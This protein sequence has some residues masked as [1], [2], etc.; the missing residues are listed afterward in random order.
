M[1]GQVVAERRGL[2][3]REYRTNQNRPVRGCRGP[4]GKKHI[5]FVDDDLNVLRGLERMLRPLRNEWEMA[6]LGKGT[7]AL[8]RL[9]QE[10]VDVIVCDLR[11]PGMDGIQLLNEVM[12]RFPR[13]VRII[14][15]G[16][17][18]K[19]TVLKAARSTHAYLSK[20]CE[21]E[22]LKAAVRQL[23]GEHELLMEFSA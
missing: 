16:Q 18:G 5:L 14:L 22:V 7:D 9:E 11:M 10:S 6:F 15:S 13:V 12:Q 3:H 8:A 23:P 17:V 1:E 20:P 21:P 2:S 4:I 19:E